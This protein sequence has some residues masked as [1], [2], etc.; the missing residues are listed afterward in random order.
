M[1]S[2]H[3]TKKQQS[4][5]R[6]VLVNY[7]NYTDTITAS[8][9]TNYSVIVRFVKNPHLHPDCHCITCRSLRADITAV[10]TAF[11]CQHHHGRTKE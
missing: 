10:M 1:V 2:R 8:A 11:W 4:M 5:F 3:G 7:T 6:K 9:I